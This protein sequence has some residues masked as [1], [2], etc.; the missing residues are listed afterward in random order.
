MNRERV[1]LDSV[2]ECP[3][4][5]PLE[6]LAPRPELFLHPSHL[7]G[8]LHVARVII[9]GFALLSA[10]GL[11]EEAPR[12]WSAAYLHD[13]ARTHDGR[14]QRHGADAVRRLATMP[15]MRA[16]FQ[17][18]GLADTDTEAVATAVTYHCTREELSARH[19]HYRLTALLKDADALDRVRLG[20]LNPDFLRFQPTRRLMGFAQAL[21]DRTQWS[22]EPGPDL[23]AR[24]WPI[25]RK[26]HQ[27]HVESPEI[28]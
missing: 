5:L 23:F 7:H 9:H 4:A 8:Q 16:L 25:A 15:E 21:H 18:G 28:E 24:M 13:L 19:P 14:C 10:L 6:A 2:L 12:L 3:I 27:F 22:L 1:R 17:R 26:L 11:R 20:D